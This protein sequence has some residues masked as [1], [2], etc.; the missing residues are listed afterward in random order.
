MFVLDLELGGMEGQAVVHVR[1]EPGPVGHPLDGALL[2]GEDASDLL[3]LLLVPLQITHS[4]SLQQVQLLLP[5]LVHGDVF[6][7]VRVEAEISVGREECVKHG[8][9]LLR[10]RG[11]ADHIG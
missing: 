8:V 7:D 2:P 3:Q 9:N 1:P 11:A 6:A 10:V 5:V 4:L